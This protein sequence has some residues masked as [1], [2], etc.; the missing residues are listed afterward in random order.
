MKDNQKH[1][2]LSERIIIEQG[3]NGGLAFAAIANKIDKDP[4]T[5]SK[6]VRKHRTLKEHRRNYLPPRCKL[7]DTCTITGLC[8]HCHGKCSECKKCLS[9]C[10]NYQPRSCGR[11]DKPPYVCNAC[12]SLC[13]CHYYR[14]IYVAKYAD[15]CYH[16]LLSSSREGINQSAEDMQV[17]D[18]IISPLLLKGQTLS[19]I[20]AHHEKE[21]MDLNCARRTLYRYLDQN[22]LSAKNLDLPRKVKYKPRRS[23]PRLSKTNPSY[24][25]KHS[26]KDFLAYMQSH[27]DMPVVEMD[28]VEG[29]KGGKVLLT[30]LFRSC[31]LMLIILLKD[32][33]QESVINVFDRLSQTIGIRTFKQL[34]PV[35]LTD[36]GVE[37]QN[38]ERLEHNVKNTNRCKIFYCDP[39]C[40][41]QKGMIEKNHEFIRYIVPKGKSFD[42]FTQD[43][44]DLIMNH[45][46][47]TARDSLNGCT[48]YR[49]SLMLLDNSLHRALSL[50]EIHPDN[51]TLKPILMK[52]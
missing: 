36:N 8:P 50:Q 1:L 21:L 37:F 7:E 46:N 16:E 51:V 6:E 33:T 19:H 44:I 12:K 28:T 23:S 5:I 29:S 22:L 20:Y 3:L 14:Y 11:L 18:T 25:I 2:T 34:F 43:D 17:I 40:S 9:V 45:I 35:I 26:Y 27:P 31:S 10:K 42:E 13:S 38:R 32:K 48:P 52:R 47:S 39:N 49:L 4:S 30:L 41:W 24:R 15:D